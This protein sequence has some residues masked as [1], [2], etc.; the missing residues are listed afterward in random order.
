MN[1]NL[2]K[3]LIQAS[4]DGLPLS[5]Q[6]LTMLQFPSKFRLT[7]TPLA[8]ELS[9]NVETKQIDYVERFLQASLYSEQV[10]E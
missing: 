9:V 10:F 2:L 7:T 8:S 5:K 1:A 3:G 6:W 4:R